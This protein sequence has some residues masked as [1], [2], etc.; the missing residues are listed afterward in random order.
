[1]KTIVRSLLCLALTLASCSAPL[2]QPLDFAGGNAGEL[3]SVLDKYEA[4]G[5]GVKM[6]AVELLIGNMRLHFGKWRGATV[7]PCDPLQWGR[8]VDDHDFG[9]LCIP[10][11]GDVVKVMPAAGSGAPRD[12][13]VGDRQADKC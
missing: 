11:R 9:P 5:D 8:A 10:R 12:I 2:R 6:A 1:M 7:P 3:Q 4:G 13:G